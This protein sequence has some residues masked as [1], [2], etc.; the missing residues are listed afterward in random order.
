MPMR[1]KA[2]IAAMLSFSLSVG[3]TTESVLPC[4]I[5]E[6]PLHILELGCRG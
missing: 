4:D 5:V 6:L 2:L 1:A 3:S